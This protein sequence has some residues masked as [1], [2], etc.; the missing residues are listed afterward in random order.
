MQDYDKLTL[1]KNLLVVGIW[2]KKQ[3]LVNEVNSKWHGCSIG[4]LAKD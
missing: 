1:K 4:K 2:I 3:V